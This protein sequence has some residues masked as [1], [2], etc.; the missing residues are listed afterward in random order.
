MKVCKF[1]GSC[2]AFGKSIKNIKSLAKDEDRK[3]LVFSALGKS[4]IDEEK[5]TDLLL[6]SYDEYEKSG[7]LLL[8]NIKIRFERLLGET[9]VSLD[10]EKEF[11]QIE[12]NF[13]KNKSRDYLVSCGEYLTAKIFA[14]MLGIKYVPCEKL[15][16]FKNGDIDFEKTSAKV[17]ASLF[18]Y[19]RI[20]TG[21]FYG[22]D[23]FGNI[24]LLSRGGGDLS[25]SIFAR[26]IKA[27]VYEIFTDV[28]GIYRM[29]P[30]LGQS[31]V[32]KKM[33][34]EDLIFITGKGA[35]VVHEDCGSVLIKTDTDL[36]VRNCFNLR[37]QGTKVSKNLNTSDSFIFYDDKSRLFF[38]YKNGKTKKVNKKCKI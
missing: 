29:S 27:S 36:F 37:H 9:K 18:K 4:S 25:G 11:S 26:V 13:Y 32:I 21:G 19:N 7:T 30:K 3:I 20:V 24:K 15:L 22:S 38:S 1:G 14:K 16:F 6:D 33:S 35:S 31:K 23:E 34:Y 5:I 10:L 2:S 8:K 12:N 17:K 28:D